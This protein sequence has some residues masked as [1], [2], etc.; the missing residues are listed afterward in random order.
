METKGIQDII[1]GSTRNSIR[2]KW[3]HSTEYWDSDK[4]N[5]TM[6][7]V[8]NMFQAYMVDGKTE[9]LMTKYFPNAYKHFTDTFINGKNIVQEIT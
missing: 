8:A 7:A 2:V 5:V 3:G 6:E 9:E 1:S 4:D